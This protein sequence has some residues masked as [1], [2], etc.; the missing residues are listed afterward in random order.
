MEHH[1]AQRGPMSGNVPSS[2]SRRVFAARLAGMLAATLLLAAGG[3]IGSCSH[4]PVGELAPASVT[5]VTLRAQRDW[6]DAIIYFVLIDRFADGDASR[7]AHVDIDNPGAWHGGDLRGLRLQLDEIASLGATALWINP[8]VKQVDTPVWAQGPPGSGWARGFEHWPFHGYWADDFQRLEPHFGSEADLKALVDAAH[9]RGLKVLLDVVYNHVGYGARYLSDPR[10]RLW[11]RVGEGDCA[12][13]SLTCAVGGLPDLRTE[14]PEVRE[15]LF[16]AHVGL[17]KRTGLDGFR[18]DTVKHV[19]HDFWKAQRARTRAEL[20][21]SFFLLAEVW[22]GSQEVLDPWFAGDEMDAGFDFSFRGNCLGFVEGRGRTVAYATYLKKRHA[23]RRGYHLA[24]YLSL[25]DEPMFLHEL[26]NDRQ[27]F[28]LCVALQM[29]N[30]GIPVIYYGEEVARRGG[31]WPTNRGDMAWG[32]RAV[33]PGEGLMRDEALRGYY[34]QLIALRRAHPALSRGTFRELSTAGDL[35]VF[36]RE[37][38]ASGD[39][40]IV[41]INRGADGAT[42]AVPLPKRWRGATVQEALTGAPAALDD[43]RLAI[44]APARTAQ[45]YVAQPR[46]TGRFAW[47]IFASRT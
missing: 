20:G 6:S 9:A 33:A 47:P 42:A 17:A 19:E 14:L 35:L 26:G 23:V 39:A 29:T 37:D 2:M 45:V 5:P 46:T 30:L 25:H 34:R 10:T 41:A 36:A 13:D 18:L 4:A 12:V 40:V 15:Y 43:G 16:N 11:L 31:A 7:N 22:G 27:K 32:S 38:P 24:H 8:V 44:Q 1:A 28:K 21:Q 3:S